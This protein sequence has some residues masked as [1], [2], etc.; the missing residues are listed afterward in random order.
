LSSV[1]SNADGSAFVWV[2]QVGD[3]KLAKRAIT[4][5]EV[6]GSTIAVTKGLKEGDIIATA[7]LSAL[8]ENMVVKP[9]TAIGE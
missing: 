9:I 1:A 4:T 6:S 2:I 3:N 7:G 5:G 8:Q